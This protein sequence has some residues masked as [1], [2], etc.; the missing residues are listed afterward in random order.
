VQRGR[1]KFLIPSAAYE[2]WE[3]AHKPILNHQFKSPKLTGVSIEVR[4]FFPDNRL[5]DTDNLLTSILDCLKDS[6]VIKDDRWQYHRSPPVVHQP[7]IDSE[8]PRVEIVISYGFE[9]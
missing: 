6:G 9:D 2:S 1:T 8:N 3:R 5:R 7:V 4:P